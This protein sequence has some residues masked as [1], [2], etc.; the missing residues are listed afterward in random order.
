MPQDFP[1]TMYQV[2]KNPST[3]IQN[4]EATVCIQNKMRI[5]G[6]GSVSENE[7]FPHGTTKIPTTKYHH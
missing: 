3:M 4:A 6:K 7:T 1:V 5:L 2:S